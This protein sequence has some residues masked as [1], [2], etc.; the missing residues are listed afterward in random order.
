VSRLSIASRRLL[1]AA[2]PTLGALAGLASLLLSPPVYVGEAIVALEAGHGSGETP[3][4]EALLRDEG[5]RALEKAMPQGASAVER[6]LA[7]LSWAPAPSA[8]LHRIRF[9]HPDAAVAAAGA[10]TA[11][12]AL[13]ELFL[14][15]AEDGTLRRH[16]AR[17]EA[18]MR[19]LSD[20]HPPDGGLADERRRAAAQGLEDIGQQYARARAARLDLEARW[21][22]LRQSQSAG[23]ASWIDSPELAS[24]REDLQRLEQRR[25]QLAVRFGP[26]WPEMKDAVSQVEAAR[27]RLQAEAQRLAAEALQEAEADYQQALAQERALERSLRA[28]QRELQTL[29]ERQRLRQGQTQRLQQLEAEAS[30]VRRRL[31]GAPG[32]SG[33]RAHIVAR[34]TPPSVPR[35]VPGWGRVLAGVLVGLVAGAGLARLSERLD[36]TLRLPGEAERAIDAPLLATVPEVVGGLP[37]GLLRLESAPPPGSDA[38]VEP[39]AAAAR[40]FRD[41]RTGLL[42]ARAGE[43]ARVVLVTGC[44]RG[45]G[46]TTVAAHLALALARRGA[47]VLL[48]DAHLTR[49]RAH[50]LFGLSPGPGLVDV[51]NGTIPLEEAVRQTSEPGLH[52]MPAGDVNG[53]GTDLLDAASL[54]HLR[55]RLLAPGRFQHLVLDAG[56]VG[57]AAAPER[58]TVACTGILIVL[59]AGR[60]PRSTVRQTAATLRRHGAPHLAGV[61][62]GPE[63]A[64]ARTRPPVERAPQVEEPAAPRD[65]AP[66]EWSQEPGEPP[67]IDPELIRRLDRLRERLGRTRG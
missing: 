15:G 43:P 24:L 16:L 66:R 7:R 28:Q 37:P 47:H 23:E 63:A 3:T 54:R 32:A 64:P 53:G 4:P 9:E 60:N 22:A 51:L 33:A 38:P 61:W 52:L 25:D 20:V 29:D 65:P 12:E 2:L 35:G 41:L 42:L 55:D 48:I 49:P 34:A 27:A 46:K 6:F 30:E 21:T 44:R 14:P 1:A 40:G 19:Q 17:L 39:L 11:A 62:I 5:R 26:L 56:D 45:E 8:Q 18:D 59:R 31:E 10:N 58:L 50:R 36:P 57:S 13:V 67:A